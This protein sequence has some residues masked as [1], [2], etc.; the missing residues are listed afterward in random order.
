MSSMDG[1]LIHIECH[2]QC[3]L[4]A[5]IPAQSSAQYMAYVTSFDSSCYVYPLYTYLSLLIVELILLVME[6]K[7]RIVKILKILG[8]C[9]LS[10]ILV[11]VEIKCDLA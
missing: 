9:L 5:P 8:Y 10:T 4:E 3:G 11:F 1:C 7:V 2:L 6:L